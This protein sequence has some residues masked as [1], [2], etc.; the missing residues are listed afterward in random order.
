MRKKRLLKSKNIIVCF[1]IIFLSLTSL[2]IGKSHKNWPILN[3]TQ[4]DLKKYFKKNQRYLDPIEG[5]WI[6]EEKVIWKNIYS[7]ITGRLNQHI[8]YKL[9]IVKNNN[10]KENKYDF[11]VII[12]ESEY[13]EWK[14]GFIKGYFNKTAF[15]NA[16]EGA[17]YNVNFSMRKY[18]FLLER[19]GILKSSYSYIYP[20]DRKFEIYV[21]ARLIKIYPP[22]NKNRI[23]PN[24][25][26]EQRAIGTGFI[27]STSGLVVTNFHVIKSINNN[28]K[29]YFPFKNIEKIAKVEVKDVSND[30]AI[31]RIEDF[32]YK[33][34]YLDKKIPYSLGD[35]NTIMLGEEVFTIGYPLGNL[36]GNTQKLSIGNISGLFG[37][38]NDP[39]FF[40]IS[41]PIQPGNSGG[42]LFNKKG[43]IIGI[44]V[45]SLNAKYFY[46]KLDTIP[47]NVNFAIKI[48]YLKNLLKMI[49]KGNELIKRKKVYQNKTIKDFVNIFK[50][51]IVEVRVTQ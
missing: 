12:L 50:R 8:P 15:G 4:Y 34:F 11:I 30:I 25:N 39:R 51:F 10:D 16:Y 5:I 41:T 28:I 21:N 48:D 37:I 17:F 35:S 46:E 18:L 32:N 27:I 23:Y 49:P 20:K 7:G 43:E 22:L 47:Q 31:L 2:F 6:F 9:A 44:V 45:S 14:K 42:P 1:I 40:Q 36:L 29:I 13:K 33:N 24:K 38:L 19:K 26:K 3:I